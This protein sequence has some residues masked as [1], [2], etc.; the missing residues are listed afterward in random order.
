MLAGN[1]DPST[2]S[3]GKGHLN[4]GNTP[5]AYSSTFRESVYAGEKKMPFF[6]HKLSQESFTLSSEFIEEFIGQ[7]PEWGPLGYVSYKRTYARQKPDG[8]YEE[9]WET[10]QR[11][12]EGCYRVQ[13]RHCDLFHLPFKLN[14]AQRSAQQ[15]Y[16]L[17]W[18]F[19]FLPPGRGLWMMGTKTIEKIGGAALCNC[20][21]VST[22]QIDVSF[23]APFCF[24]MDHSMLGVGVGSDAR[25]AGKV[26]LVQPEV[27]SDIHVVADTREGW[28]LAVRRLLESYVG[29]TTLPAIWDFSQVRRAGTL[30]K[31]FGGVAAG[32]E[33]LRLLIEE[34]LP[35][36][37]NKAIGKLITSDVIVDVHNLIGKC[38]VSGNVRRSAEIMFSEPEDQTF[39]E[40][41]D[42]SL[43]PEELNNHRWASNNSIFAREGMDYTPIAEQTVMNGEPGYLWLDNARRFG[44]MVDPPN[45]HDRRVVGSNPCGEQ[46][47]ESFELCNLVETFPS[48]HSSYK[49]YEITLKFAY[50][51]AKTVTL[52]PTHDQRTNA[53]QLRNRRIGTSQSGITNSFARHGRRAHFQWCDKGYKYLRE[54]D[55]I[56]SEWLCVVTS[57]RITTVKPSGTVSLLPGVAPG[58]HYPISEFYIR[59]IR[60]GT[61]SRILRALAKAGYAIEPAVNTDG[62]FVVSIPVQ[63]QEFVKCE[64][65]VTMWEQLENV[66]GMQ[67]WWSDNSVSVTI[68]FDP[69]TEGASLADALEL[70][71]DRLKSV[72]F[73]PKSEHGYVQAP[74]EPITKEQ[75]HEMKS[76]LKPLDLSAAEHEVDEKFCD[77][78]SCLIL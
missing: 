39:L 75:Y 77:G 74:Y 36:V 76:K 64:S 48:R 28:V 73:L 67:K 65:D 2:K 19:K 5:P 63:E 50:L 9:F 70:F 32:P 62:T 72:S 6:S 16:R 58:I 43:H 78:D 45:N 66:A 1:Q 22:A 7:Q 8:S 14:K 13:Q 41:K 37:L 38:V 61:G 18:D 47:L 59:R 51:F 54:L 29:K 60:I 27:S 30:I 33:P 44:R 31:G 69:K 23:S 49:E 17:M 46:M 55:L 21:F 57:K 40:L 53:I 15:M 3:N 26:V 42:P 24:L 56:Y 12:V 20:A 35:R 10:L 4:P 34:E 11:V 25:G 68:K 52:I 71:E